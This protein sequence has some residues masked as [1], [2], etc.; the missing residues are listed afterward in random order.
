MLERIDVL[1]KEL[2]E[3]ITFVLAYPTVYAN[4]GLL[5]RMEDRMEQRGMQNGAWCSRDK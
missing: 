5:I 4:V 3:T 2:L 1:A